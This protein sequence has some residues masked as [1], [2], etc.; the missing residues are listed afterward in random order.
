MVTP[1]QKPVLEPQIISCGT[2]KLITTIDP[3]T[4]VHYAICDLC[5]QK[6]KLSTTGSPSQMI[7]HRNSGRCKKR[8]KQQLSGPPPSSPPAPATSLPSSAVID[9]QRDTPP[10]QSDYAALPSFIY[11]QNHQSTQPS[12]QDPGTCPGFRI[13]LVHIYSGYAYGAHESHSWDWEPDGFHPETKE[14]RLRSTKCQRHATLD[15]A[16]CMS[17]QI[18]QGS[19]AFRRFLERADNAPENTPWIYLTSE[20]LHALMHAMTKTLNQLRTEV[21]T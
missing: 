14:L 9:Q 12:V 1:R 18:V 8:Q 5:S 7:Q 6:V 19:S 10:S 15:G 13:H 4:G 20:Q 3:D 21:C 2:A 16:S 11:A 17:C